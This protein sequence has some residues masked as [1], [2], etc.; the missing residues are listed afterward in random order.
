MYICKCIVYRTCMYT[1][2][3][4]HVYMYQCIMHLCVCIYVYLLA[5]DLNYRSQ[6]MEKLTKGPVS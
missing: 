2:E 4:L 5:V 3:Y 6:N 1:C